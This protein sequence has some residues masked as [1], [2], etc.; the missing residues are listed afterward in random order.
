MAE[1]SDPTIDSSGVNATSKPDSKAMLEDLIAQAT[2]QYSIKNYTAAAELYSEA[3]ELQAEVNGEMSPENADLL[4]YYGRCLYH[5]GVSKSNVLGA[6]VAGEKSTDGASSSKGKASNGDSGVSAASYE[7]TRVAEELVE[8]VVEEKDSVKIA[9]AE[10]STEKQPYFQFTGDE[11]F[12]DSGDDDEVAD[13]DETGPTEGAV[14][15]DD[16]SIA[17]EVL[18]LARVLLVRQLEQRQETNGKGKNTG[19]S[20]DVKQIKERLAD[21]HDLQAEI[22]LENERFPSAV[23]DLKSALLLKQ[24][25]FP[26]DSS[27][28]AEAHFK[29]SLA[30]E[31]AS[32]STEK[33]EGDDP[34]TTKEAQVDEDMREAAAKEMEAAIESCKL[35]VAKESKNLELKSS[36]QALGQKKPI[37][38]ASIDEVKEMIS[39]MEQR[40][41]DLRSPSVSLND[42]T[43]PA[44]APD[45]SD[46]LRGIL[47]SLL[48]ETQATQRARVEE[49][50][51]AANDVSGLVRRKKPAAKESGG[52]AQ[53]GSSSNN[54]KRKV[55]SV[56]KVE[57]V[58]AASKKAKV[59]D[60][61]KE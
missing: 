40:L 14:E 24:E 37:T 39:E 18:D 23:T 55:D 3:T 46:P 52:D 6:K 30:L 2:L 22:Y 34:A 51:K 38:K 16:F 26:Q 13:G 35:R 49:A 54:G 10:I 60:Q 56:D 11:N 12:D 8:K 1:T 4:Y 15:E 50:T 53:S 33:G 48:G 44:G 61:A 45:G 42:Q 59:E 5:V 25:L 19:N 31:F 21:T 20:E 7:E 32:V 58:N 43:G 9:E 29:L 17:F 57:D 36:S 28:I 47:G 27:L 41:L